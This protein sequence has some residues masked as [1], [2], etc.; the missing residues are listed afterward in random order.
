VH[1]QLADWPGSTCSRSRYSPDTASPA[2]VTRI[3]GRSS[4]RPAWWGW[5]ARAGVRADPPRRDRGDPHAGP[6]PSQLRAL[7]VSR[8]GDRRHAGM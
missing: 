3:G 8:R 6:E 4:K 1:A 7:P 2:S 5:S